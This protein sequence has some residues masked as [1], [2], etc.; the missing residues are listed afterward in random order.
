MRLE[1]Q[2]L[3]QSCC[4]G[5]VHVPLK[6]GPRCLS[7]GDALRLS[8]ARKSQAPLSFGSVLHLNW[9][10][11]IRC[12][13]CM[14]ERWPGR[15]TKSWLCDFCHLDVYDKQRDGKRIFKG[16]GGTQS[17]DQQW[18]SFGKRPKP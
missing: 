14:F 5:I 3:P 1:D 18:F 12:R 4:D 7:L 8:E 13:P 2:F 15:C 10:G 9:D 6:S 11:K 17:K 16:S